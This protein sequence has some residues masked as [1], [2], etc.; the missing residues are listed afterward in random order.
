MRGWKAAIRRVFTA[1]WQRCRLSWMRN[2]L[3]DVAKT[4]QNMVAAAL[5]QAGRHPAG[6]RAQASQTFPVTWPISCGRNGQSS[7]RSLT[8]ARP[9]FCRIWTSPEQHRTRLH[10]TNSAGTTEQGSRSD[11]PT[12]VGIFP[13]EPSIV[14]LRSRR[15]AAG[16]R[17]MSSITRF[18]ERRLKLQVNMEKSAV[19]RPWQRSFLG[20]TI[21]GKAELRRC[22]AEKALARFKKLT[23]R[24]ARVSVHGRVTKDLNP[25]LRGWAG[26]FGSSQWR[27]LPTLDAWVRRRLRCLA[28]V[29]WRTV[30]RRIAGLCRRGVAKSAAFAAAWVAKGPWRLSASGA[31][32]KAF[33]KARFRAMGLVEMASFVKA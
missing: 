21:R 32:H 14:R 18:I 9:T 1:T 13:N 8:T 17:A 22:V 30:R 12:M 6:S 2:A 28:W 25:F 19:G 3:S 11:A 7:R 5:R 4:Q 16:H 31:L 24:S 20:Y 26:Y 27:E 23:R 29:Q 10:S 15:E 33:G